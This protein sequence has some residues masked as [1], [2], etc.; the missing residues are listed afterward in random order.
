MKRVKILLII[1]ISVLFMACG[2]GDSDSS[3]GTSIVDKY[4]ERGRLTVDTYRQYCNTDPQ[5]YNDVIKNFIVI[6]NVEAEV[7]ADLL[8]Y[9]TDNG[10]KPLFDPTLDLGETDK[11]LAEMNYDSMIIRSGDVYAALQPCLD[12]SF[13][14]LQKEPSSTVRSYTQT[15]GLFKAAGDFFSWM[16]GTR[17]HTRD[18]ILTI[19]KN[20]A[21]AKQE[22]YDE[23]KILWQNKDFGAN[24]DEFMKKLQTGEFDN[25]VNYL[26][27]SLSD[28]PDTTYFM[29]V[30]EKNLGFMNKTLDEGKEGIKKGVDLYVESAKVIADGGLGIEGGGFS[31]G[32]DYAKNT[33]EIVGATEKD[34]VSGGFFKWLSNKTSQVLGDRYKELLKEKAYLTEM[35][36]DGVKDYTEAY[37]KDSAAAVSKTISKYANG[38][39]NYF[40]TP[41]QKQESIDKAKEVAK[42]STVEDDTNNKVIKIDVADDQNIKNPDLG[43]VIAHD[44]NGNME[45]TVVKEDKEVLVNTNKDDFKYLDML[46]TNDKND[47][48]YTKN[49]PVADGVIELTS[50]KEINENTEVLTPDTDKTVITFTSSVKGK[51]DTFTE[52][53]VMVDI[54]NITQKTNINFSVSS[55]VSYTVSPGIHSIES[56]QVFEVYVKVKDKDVDLKVVMSYDNTDYKNEATYTLKTNV[57]ETPDTPTTSGG[58]VYSGT[59]TGYGDGCPTSGSISF[60]MSDTSAKIILDGKASSISV[61][62]HLFNGQDANGVY[63]AGALSDDNK[64]EGTFSTSS[65]GGEFHLSN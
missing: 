41:E 29:I 46:F 14:Y 60:E 42:D 52:Y 39:Y 25:E 6:S 15:R 4:D 59:Y 51:T 63:W 18:Q 11:T 23:A 36:A 3:D 58:G 55:P 56:D 50:F 2:G 54:K 1:M 61:S 12:A 57:V 10:T 31:K 49:L 28:N 53:I 21:Q 13:T 35:F 30:Q 9:F 33:T 22:V 37:L 64:V 44:G 65:C 26:H 19:M 20:D 38:V 7:Y 5:T 24:P 62:N 32:Y 45:I 27:K 34:G 48:A 40:A 17:T 8:N 16:G 47:N 43:L